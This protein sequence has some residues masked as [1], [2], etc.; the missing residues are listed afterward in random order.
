MKWQS[1]SP[2]DPG[3]E[4]VRPL[5]DQ[6]KTV[7]RNY[8]AENRVQFREDASNAQ[9]DIQRNR[10]RHELLPLLRR[11][12]QPAL[13]EVILR[14]MDIV[15]A[16][17]EFVADAATE[18]ME[19]M[20]VKRAD[21][22]RLP[23]ALQRRCVQMHLLAQGVVPDFELVEQLRLKPNRPVNVSRDQ[24][25]A[26]VLDDPWS[27]SARHRGRDPV[28]FALRDAQGVV[29]LRHKDEAASGSAKLEL[30]LGSRGEIEFDGVSVSWRI[31]P[32]KGMRRPAP[33]N[34]HKVRR[35]TAGGA[36][37]FDADKVGSPIMQRHWQAGDRFQP[38]GMAKPVKLQDLFTNQKV[39]RPRRHEATVATNAAGE[40]FWVEGLRI[41]E[42]FKLTKATKRRLQW[43]WKRL[44]RAR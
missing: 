23:L 21:F 43:K 15:G 20:G 40:V 14:A 8:A 11:H 18:W 44:A 36:E 16:E 3:I 25:S 7:L 28:L 6:P 12:Y 10:V 27:D 1:H 42:R 39:P 30:E 9:R 13:E 29:R 33:S 38:I 4:L 41:G 26:P 2:S 34:E 37:Y 31:I 32:E 17:A 5:L 24:F 22:D 19:A 35:A